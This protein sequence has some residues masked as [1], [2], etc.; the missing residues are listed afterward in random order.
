[1][2][3]GLLG[4]GRIGS[5]HAETLERSEAVDAV[6]IF[7]PIPSRAGA[8]A[9]SIGAEVA[10]SAEELMAA[11]DAVLIASSTDS[12]A[13]DLMMAAAAGLPTFCEKPIAI[14]L[15]STDRAIDA[16]E[17]AGVPVMMG[18]NRR[19]DSGF[20][21]ARAAVADGTIGDL[22]LVVG[23]HHDYRPSPEEYIA[24]SGG[25][26]KDQLIH[27][28]DLVRFV[29]GDEVT[30]VHAAGSTV[31]PDAYE[32]HGDTVSTVV[33]LWLTSGAIASLSGARLDPNGYDVRKEVFGT[34]DSISVGWDDHTPIRRV[35]SGT[36]PTDPYQEWLA[37][38]G[39]SYRAEI[40][41]FLSMAR[42]EIASP[43]TV[44][45]ARAALVIAEACRRSLERSG[46]VELEEI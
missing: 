30:A 15:E 39:D 4:A 18:F 10:E 8:L 46:P 17:R 37:R 22:M 2:R 20:S 36:A 24:V 31:G 7:D 27:D 16:V 38:F 28:F 35:E 41:A 1:M 43:C 3:I 33:T 14:D 6:T 25:Q 19:F 13:D 34:G 40:D 32:R 26:Y 42:G 12:H 45:D 21:K 44:H 5:L 29:S 9:A 11:S 23:Q